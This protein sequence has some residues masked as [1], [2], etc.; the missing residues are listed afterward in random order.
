MRHSGQHRT[1]EKE[2]LQ[3]KANVSFH[4]YLHRIW[5][6][7]MHCI[8]ARNKDPKPCKRS[9]HDTDERISLA[10]ASTVTVQSIAPVCVKS[11]IYSFAA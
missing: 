3:K 10:T 4:T 5:R 11:K 1:K 6:P 7:L 8:K 9:C 2:D